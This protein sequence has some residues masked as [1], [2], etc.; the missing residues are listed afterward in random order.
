MLIKACI[1]T[2]GTTVFAGPVE[3]LLVG[4]LDGVVE[5]SRSSGNGAWKLTDQMLRGY[6]ISALF[7]EPL[8]GGIFAGVH[9]EGLFLSRDGG[10][11]WQSRTTG[12][13]TKHIYTFGSAQGRDG[14]IIYAGT[15]PAQIY[16]S[17]NYAETWEELSSLR[18]V[19]NTDKWMFPPPPHVPHVKTIAIDPRDPAVMYVGVEQGALLKSLDGGATWAELSTYYRQDDPVYKDTH[20][21]ILLPSNPDKIFMTSGMGLVTS[22]DAGETWEHL[23]DTEFRIGYPEPA[24]NFTT[25]RTDY[26]YGRSRERPG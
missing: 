1:S 15:E 7:V 20:R 2:D 4:T 26:V 16:R 25:R 12:L 14:A 6:H 22:P 5:L 11:T 18:A 8:Q 13:S 23:T 3:T 10:K 19:P 21:L 17:S 24:S 9:G